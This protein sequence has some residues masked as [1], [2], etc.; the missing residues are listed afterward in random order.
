MKSLIKY[1]NLLRILKYIKL[2]GLS[3]TYYE[4]KRKLILDKYS[5][6]KG[7]RVTLIQKNDYLADDNSP[8]YTVSVVIPTKDAGS[9]F[10][11]LL[12]IIKNQ[13]G[14]KV[15]EIIIV[16]SG[17]EDNTISIAESHN[18]KIIKIKSG[19]FTHSYARNLGAENATGDYILF[20]VQDACPTNDKWL[21]ELLNVM[22][23][24]EVSAISCTETPSR[25]CDLFYNAIIWNYSL[26]METGHYGKIMKKPD[27]E[28]HISL[29]KNA[30]INNV[31]CL[32]SKDL[33]SKY[34]FNSIYAEDL[35]L[36]LRLIRDGHKLALTN[37]PSIIH[38]HNRPAYYHLKRG[39]IEQILH[40][41]LFPDQPILSN[42]LDQTLADILS[43]YR[44]LYSTL[45][46]RLRDVKLPCTV[47][48]LSKF[49]IKE[50]SDPENLISYDFNLYSTNKYIDYDTKNF[51]GNI[52]ANYEHTNISSNCALLQVTIS[53]I[54]IIL[55]YVDNNHNNFDFELVDELKFSIFKSFALISGR[56]LGSCFTN[57]D[58][59][60]KTNYMHN[61]NN[62]LSHNV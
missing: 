9:E 20:T 7:S 10:E 52:S 53:Y 8:N 15:I 43:V 25:D 49:I 57:L 17:S 19:D 44:I 62:L 59:S 4:F 36:G 5:S 1:N 39:Y 56:F 48:K 38:S 45:F 6:Y 37:Y 42:N 61:I 41:E 29:K 46:I 60:M 32:I 33:I 58:S 11:D 21:I 27:F 18:V 26:F 30:Q 31:A 24:T 54:M 47:S 28:D 14:F 50:I 3:Y 13:K 55:E 34:K 22:I 16:D 2:F 23:N 40:S 12:S 35:E 51:L